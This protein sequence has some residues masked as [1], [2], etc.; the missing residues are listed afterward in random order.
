MIS[1]KFKNRLFVSNTLVMFVVFAIMV[2]LCALCPYLS[3]DWHFKFVWEEIYPHSDVKP[4]E[5]FGDIVTSMKNYYKYNGGRLICQTIAYI[6]SNLNKW[7]YNIANSVIFVI[8]GR[9]MYALLKRRLKDENFGRLK[10]Y[11]FLALP[12]IYFLTFFAVPC[13]GD[14][15][16]W[17]SGSCNYM[18][19]ETLLFFTFWLIERYFDKS[20]FGGGTWLLAWRY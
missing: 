17:I 8:Q 10:K 20:S 19:P 18:I 14:N 16:L 5:N 13:F 15:V 12:L 11:D 7:V 6:F 3:D 1:N 4:V 2:F 9:L